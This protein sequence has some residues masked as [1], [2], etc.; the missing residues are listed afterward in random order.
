MTRATRN[1]DTII[2]AVAD[3][4]TKDLHFDATNNKRKLSVSIDAGLCNSGSGGDDDDVNIELANKKSRPSEIGANSP[5]PPS[6]TSTLDFSRLRDNQL[7]PLVPGEFGGGS[8]GGAVDED[9]FDPDQY[10]VW[11]TSRKISELTETEFGHENDIRRE[12]GIPPIGDNSDANHDGR[13]EKIVEYANNL[14]QVLRQIINACVNM[15]SDDDFDR[16]VYV[17]SPTQSANK[18]IDA[19]EIKYRIWHMFDNMM[20]QEKIKPRDKFA[21]HLFE[22]YDSFPDRILL[23]ADRI[24]D[25]LLSSANERKDIQNNTPIGMPGYVHFD[26]LRSVLVKRVLTPKVTLT[27]NQVDQMQKNPNQPKFNINFGR[28]RLNISDFFGVEKA[29]DRIKSSYNVENTILTPYYSNCAKTLIAIGEYLVKQLNEK[30]LEYLR[31]ENEIQGAVAA[32]MALSRAG[33]WDDAAAAA[34]A[35]PAAPA[36]G[37][38]SNNHHQVGSTIKAVKKSAATTT[39]DGGATSSSTSGV[40]SLASNGGGNGAGSADQIE[41]V[42]SGSVQPKFPT[43]RETLLNCERPIVF[44]VEN[45]VHYRS[46]GR[47]LPGKCLS[48]MSKS[49]SDK[50]RVCSAIDHIMY[51]RVRSM[52]AVIDIKECTLTLHAYIGGGII[53]GSLVR[54]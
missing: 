12:M 36:T 15:E 52:T 10:S 53:V 7:S 5:L 9:C 17:R 13:E 34:S 51:G 14:K 41:L 50:L 19:T 38:N 8:G 22:R 4:T 25:A 16:S 1:D 43:L 29:G 44:D 35:T 37:A 47:S 20:E 45:G 33:Q 32:V 54:Y 30:R 42:E 46:G 11:C 27:P 2:R 49:G 3:S 31:E 21:K 48:T 6:P 23:I 18:E 26:A 39:N 28:I 40:I 24:L